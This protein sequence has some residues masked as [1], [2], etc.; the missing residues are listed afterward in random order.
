MLK[1][2]VPAEVRIT[3]IV[4]VVLYAIAYSSM[5]VTTAIVTAS[6]PSDPT[7]FYE[8]L[9]IENEALDN[10][11]GKE[12]IKKHCEFFC[13]ICKSHVIKGAKHCQFCN[14]CTY[15]FDHHCR[16]VGNDIGRLNYDMFI[17]MLLATMATLLFQISLHIA[18]LTHLSD[19]RV[20]E[21]ETY[22]CKT[23]LTILNYVTL[24]ISLI[25][26]V[27]VCL[28]LGFHT[29]IIKHNMTTL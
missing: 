8:K 26:L 25:S 24:V 29:Y 27:A 19:D 6:D 21:V 7:V 3:V 4:L 20:G 16:W 22:M 13:S 15:G 5:I 11:S 9:L 1:D 2:N 18:A 17:R 12:L 14:R 23:D 10:G 28:L